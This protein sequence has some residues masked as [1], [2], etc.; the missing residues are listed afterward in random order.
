[1]QFILVLT[2]H[3]ILGYIFSPYLVKREVN[4]EFCVT[5]D[6]ITIQKLPQYS[7]ILSPEQVQLVKY[8]ENYN[9]QNLFKLF[10]K[11]K[12]T[13]YDFVNSLDK[14]LFLAHVRPYI[15]R[16]LV[17]CFDLMQY[18]PQPV[19]HKILQNKIYD[20]DRIEIVDREN[21]TIFNFVRTPEGIRYKL[22]IE[23]NSHILS[24]NG[25]TGIVLVNEPCC[26]AI[27]NTLFVL[28]DID[29]KKLLPFFDKESISISKQTEKKYFQSFVKNAI[30]KYKVK[31]E[32]FTID[33]AESK[34][35]GVVSLE[36]NLS[37]HL[38]LVLKFLYDNS[39]FYANRRSGMRVSCVFDSDN[40][41]FIRSARDN[42]FENSCISKLLSLGLVNKDGPFFEILSRK[43]KA[44]C[45]YGPVT[46]LNANKN[47]LVKAGFDV[48]Q[49]NLDKDYYLGR[50]ELKLEVSEQANDW[51]D[52]NAIVIFEEFKIPFSFFRDHITGGQRE[53]LLPNNKVMILPEEWFESYSDLIKFSKIEGTRFK[54]NKKH[55]SLLKTGKLSGNF[56][57]NLKT[58]LSD[59]GEKHEEIPGGVEAELRSYQ[60]EGYTWMYRLFRNG[61]GGCLADDMGLGK[62][63]QTLTLLMRVTS[64]AP[65]DKP[66]TNVKTDIQLSLFDTPA[67]PCHD[68]GQKKSLIVV[69]TSLIHNWINECRKFVPSLRV[70][71]FAG[72]N[73]GSLCHALS[74]TDILITSYGILRNDLEQFSKESFF[75]VVLDESQTIKNPGSK[76]YSAVNA[77]DADNRIVLSGTP[78]ENSLSDL[79]AQFN[80]INPGLLGNLQFFQSEFQYPIEKLDDPHKKEKLR[81]LIAPFILRRTKA[82]V[83]RELPDLSEQIIGC[84]MNE[85][86]ETYYEREKSKARNLIMEN[87]NRYGLKKSSMQ[88]LA[89]LM[90]LRQIANH[91]ALLDNDY[92]SGSGKFDEIRRIVEN[93]HTEGH[94]ALI[95]SS[96]VEHLN[97]VAE[98]L[99]NQGV[100]FVILTGE[101]RNRE[102][103]VAHFQDDDAV[104][105]F[106]ISL[107][108]GGVG[109]NLT[110]ASYVLMLDPW[111]NPAAEKQ[112]I[113][114]AH[115]IGQDK[116]VMVYR[117]ISQNTLE[118]KIVKLQERKSELADIFVN[119]NTFSKFTEE[120]ILELFD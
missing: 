85:A 88:I 114:R 77:L 78:I 40:V 76:T 98:W 66:A 19:Y 33:E 12:S 58:L 89:S 15:E 110:A 111:W 50:V 4:K 26:I 103:V 102:E 81:Q 45:A 97:L 83:A 38:S 11:K 73:R 34:P 79:W 18:N 30:A 108:A 99:K 9:D 71:K 28:R 25:K 100:G 47:L 35:R 51:F 41:K 82:Q 72:Q 57:D 107:K 93:L 91:P 42:E 116:N 67:R 80:F 87:I 101:T 5:Y 10:C 115:R 113:N 7:E 48:A 53:Y 75:Y 27:D 43:E 55:F 21:N 8:I 94:K 37:G 16:Q 2:E 63:L 120:E 32:G 74:K 49:A 3:R 22:T 13:P 92:L 68:S 52:I 119:E 96:F 56:R 70:G 65:G 29:S 69:P 59:T 17:N 39:V 44:D 54:L 20:S 60:A 24:L 112:A 23:H 105:F 31:A 6:K 104:R 61:F 106:L 84:E 95:F 117:F 14:E 64:D 109:L 46:W 62:T 118:E 90:K 36:R 86:Q 1:M